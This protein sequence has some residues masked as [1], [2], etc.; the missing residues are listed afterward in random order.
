MPRSKKE[1]GQAQVE[2]CHRK[3][4]LT[5]IREYQAVGNQCRYVVDHAD[6]DQDERALERWICD[7]AQGA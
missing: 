4:E 1:V 2:H 6:A 3:G 5:P 7:L